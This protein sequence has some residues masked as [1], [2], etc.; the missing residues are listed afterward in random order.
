LL[1]AVRDYLTGHPLV[2]QF[3]SGKQTEGG[4]GVTIVTMK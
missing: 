4:N 3:R 2:E 1:K